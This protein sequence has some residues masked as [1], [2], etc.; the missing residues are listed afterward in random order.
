MFITR[1]AKDEE[2]LKGQMLEPGKIKDFKGLQ[3]FDPDSTYRVM[4]KMHWIEKEKVIFSTNTERSPVYYTFCQLDFKIG[5]SLCTLIAY[6][7]D[8]DG[9]T[10]LFIPFKDL[11]NTQETYGGGRYIEVPYRGEKD[12]FEL[13]FNLAF[14]P[15]CHYNHGYSCP[16]VPA[17][18][19]LDLPIK[20]GEK[21]L[22][23]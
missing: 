1:A 19:R 8:A 12:L 21:K 18:N 9:K 20:A 22:Y 6:A 2:I 15:Y 11:T 5:D 23:D 16:L 3:Y 14:N 4:A 13:D 10:G 7:E 17:G